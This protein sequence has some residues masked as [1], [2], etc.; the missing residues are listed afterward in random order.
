VSAQ[1]VDTTD[2]RVCSSDCVVGVED[3]CPVDYYCEGPTGETGFCL[4]DADKPG[5]CSVGGDRR[6]AMLLS[7]GILAFVLRRRR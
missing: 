1:C 6:A 2:G 3:S 7:L 5:C 4:L